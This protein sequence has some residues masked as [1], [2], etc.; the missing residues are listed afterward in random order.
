MRLS[1]N[2]EVRK[3]ILSRIPQ[4]LSRFIHMKSFITVTFS[5]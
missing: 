2:E 4:G 3:D 1:K 5:I